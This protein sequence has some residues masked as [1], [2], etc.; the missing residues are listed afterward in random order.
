LVVR[1]EDSGILNTVSTA[2]LLRGWRVQRGRQPERYR[3]SLKPRF[4]LCNLPAKTKNENHISPSENNILTP[5]TTRTVR[6]CKNFSSLIHENDLENSQK[7]VP[8]TLNSSDISL[9][10]YCIS[11]QCCDTIPLN[12]YSSLETTR[13]SQL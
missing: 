12:T 10:I 9:G 5:P 6:S 2:A 11:S 1:I 3:T 8:A 4:Q 7:Y 13:Y